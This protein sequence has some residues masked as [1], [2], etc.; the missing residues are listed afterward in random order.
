MAGAM[1]QTAAL[2]IVTA[3]T[4]VIEGQPMSRR[5]RSALTS[6][7]FD[8]DGH[9]SHQLT[10]ADVS[11]ADLILAM[12]GEHVDY[13]RRKHPQAAPRT[14]SIRRLVRDLPPGP[15]ELPA[16]LAD[17]GL[18]AL[19]VEPWEDVE[20]PAGADDEVYEACARELLALCTELG[21]RL[22]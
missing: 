20:D 6:L 22:V 16:R 7:G 9:R 11:A 13:I 19:P 21:P 12:A 15:P 10:D 2:E 4:H 1:L 14:A 17:L 5:T 8:A 3:G 18:A